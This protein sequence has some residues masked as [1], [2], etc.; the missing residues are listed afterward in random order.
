MKLPRESTSTIE[1]V[2]LALFVA[3]YAWVAL[4]VYGLI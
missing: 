4:K 1:I 2:A 3:V